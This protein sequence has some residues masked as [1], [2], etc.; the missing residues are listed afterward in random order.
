MEV[1]FAFPAFLK[2]A[3]SAYFIW[4]P[5]ATESFFTDTA[6]C[7]LVV[8]FK[9]EIFAGVSLNVNNSAYGEISPVCY[10]VSVPVNVFWYNK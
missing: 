6:A 7:F 8:L 5:S 2:L 10:V 9:L 1:I 4:Y 3:L